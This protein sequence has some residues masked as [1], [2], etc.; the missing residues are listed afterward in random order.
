MTDKARNILAD[1]RLLFAVAYRNIWRNKGR[2]LTLMT[3]VSLG[4]AGGMIAISMGQ[5]M[6]AQRF[7]IVIEKNFSHLQIH[8]P[9]WSEQF[10]V[11]Y[12]IADVSQVESA[13]K[14]E[15]SYLRHCLRTIATGIVQSPTSSGAVQIRGIDPEAERQVTAFDEL[16]VEGTYLSTEEPMQVLIGR[17]LAN[18]LN[19]GLGSRIVL[20]FT[21]REYNV[22]SSAF[23]VTG[24]FR[25]V[26]TQYDERN[27]F[28]LR[29][30]LNR[31]LGTDGQ[32][33]EVAVLFTDENKA[34]K[35]EARLAAALP[36]LLVQSWRRL[37]PELVYLQD[38]GSRV[39]YIFIIII[40]LGLS[41]GILNT[42]LMIV[43]ERT[44]ELGML[45]AIGLN[46]TRTFIMLQLETLMMTLL[47]TGVGLLIGR[48]IL[49]PLMG[50]I[51]LNFLSDALAAFGIP[52][53]VYPV[54]EP[55]F[56]RNVITLVLVFSFLASLYPS[57]KALQ[58]NPADAVRV[59]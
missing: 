25:S 50:G 14:K 45:K 22:I 42:M 23:K 33:H 58:I 31:L 41:F 4:L 18:K 3:A 11:K 44:H 7:K 46:K 47:G 59:Q 40:M 2:S 17:Q 55:D 54:I 8:H 24:I 12:T 57:W 9:K 53:M 43:H 30:D 38:V 10:E 13:L 56:Y 1:L 6:I 19:V 21:D 16:M 36:T 27:V 49:W 28:V 15:P 39:L 32:A 52:T 51:D 20:S 37:S 29:S 5:G 34:V 26:S 48:L 35:A